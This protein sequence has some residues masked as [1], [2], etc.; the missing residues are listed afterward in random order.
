MICLISIQVDY[1]LSLTKYSSKDHIFSKC[2]CVWRKQVS[3]WWN[4]TMVYRDGK[5]DNTEM[6]DL[7]SSTK[8]PTASVLVFSGKSFESHNQRRSGKGQSILLTCEPQTGTNTVGGRLIPLL[9]SSWKHPGFAGKH[10]PPTGSLCNDLILP[11]C[12][13]LCIKGWFLKF[14]LVLEVKAKGCRRR[15][16]VFVSLLGHSVFP[17]GGKSPDRF[18]LFSAVVQGRWCEV[19]AG[20]LCVPPGSQYLASRGTTRCHCRSSPSQRIPLICKAS[21]NPIHSMLASST[22]KNAKGAV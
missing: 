6:S 16:C 18:V 8:T 2:T 14:P 9:V 10:S 12:L 21:E 5:S 20:E 13:S 7:I 1:N 4:Y 11:I 19:W 15:R 3:R 22:G 17:G